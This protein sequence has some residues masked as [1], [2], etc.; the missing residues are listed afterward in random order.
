MGGLVAES[1]GTEPAGCWPC[2][3]I[4]VLLPDGMGE[5]ELVVVQS[6]ELKNDKIRFEIR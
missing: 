5:T 3:V 2:P 6:S 1:T 4:T